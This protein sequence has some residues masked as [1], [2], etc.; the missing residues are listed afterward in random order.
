MRVGHIL[1]TRRVQARF[2]A[3]IG[4]LYFPQGIIIWHIITTAAIH[5]ILSRYPD[6]LSFLSKFCFWKVLL[7]KDYNR[8]NCNSFLQRAFCCFLSSMVHLVTAIRKRDLAHLCKGR[9]Y[10]VVNRTVSGEN[11]F[12]LK[13]RERLGE[14]DPVGD[15]GFQQ[16]LSPIQRLGV[17][18][19]AEGAVEKNYEKK[20][21]GTIEGCPVQC[22]H[23][24]FQICKAEDWSVIPPA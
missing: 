1:Q 17:A 6:S 12:L 10:A 13:K 19:L 11:G 18:R 7:D 16:S 24:W 20:S 23:W 22:S 15:E 5:C 9:D 3:V 2:P 14:W 21:K 8:Q 4:A